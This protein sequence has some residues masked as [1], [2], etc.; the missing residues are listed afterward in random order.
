MTHE[1]RAWDMPS[2]KMITDFSY[3]QFN[4]DGLECDKWRVVKIKEKLHFIETDKCNGVLILY[5]GLLDKN[6]K[7]IYEGDIVKIHNLKKTWKNSPP[8][9]DW[10]IFEIKWNR[11]TW[12]FSNS[13]LYMP[14]SDYDLST[15]EPFEIE[16]L[17]NKFEN[18]ELLK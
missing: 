17:G 7:K 12:A 11:Y 6:G 4:P 9:F 13:S 8:D 1:F 18:S 10:R 15:A 2:K 3:V 16:I 5:T 14:M